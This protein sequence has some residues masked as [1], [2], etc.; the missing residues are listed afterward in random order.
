[1]VEEDEKEEE[2]KET[3]S[4]E[5][6]EAVQKK[7]EE[8][9]EVNTSEAVEIE[10]E[11]SLQFDLEKDSNSKN[12]PFVILF[13]IIFIAGAAGWAMYFFKCQQKSTPA[14]SLSEVPTVAE[15]EV[16]EATDEAEE[17]TQSAEDK[18]KT[19][20]ETKETEKEETDLSE[21]SLKILNGSGTAGEAASVQELLEDKGFEKFT[22]DNAD[23]YDYEETEVR[24][25]KDVPASVLESIKETLKDYSVVEKETLS[26]DAEYQV[27]IIVGSQKS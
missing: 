23:S 16:S 20:E 6:E 7:T 9:K 22:T 25:K 10:T 4:K 17:A 15:R 3:A 12:V 21:Y 1:M 24:L 19:E 18:E 26:Q 5:A 2:K 11:P 14:A 27:E 13:V 8:E